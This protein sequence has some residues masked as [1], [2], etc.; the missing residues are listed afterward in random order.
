MTCIILKVNQTEKKKINWSQMQYLCCT[1]WRTKMQIPFSPQKK[2]QLTFYFLLPPLGG[3]LLSIHGS[4]LPLLFFL[5]LDS[6]LSQ[7]YLHIAV[8]LIRAKCLPDVKLMDLH[9]LQWNYIN[10]AEHLSFSALFFPYP[11]DLYK[12]MWFLY[13]NFQ[14]KHQKMVWLN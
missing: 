4:L 2:L 9:W 13:N 14:G 1:F 12:A 10:A 3:I 7:L 5:S 11:L 8:Q 6:A